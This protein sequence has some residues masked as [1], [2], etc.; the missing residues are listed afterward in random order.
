MSIYMYKYIY[1][2]ILDII[3]INSFQQQK[4]SWN[5]KRKQIRNH[6]KGSK[7]AKEILRKFFFYF[8]H[9]GKKSHTLSMKLTYG[10]KRK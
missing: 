9:G 7:S 3:Y 8:V 4:L 10:V 5:C 1:A 2:Y 6:N